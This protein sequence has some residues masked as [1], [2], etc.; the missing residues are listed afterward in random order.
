[1]RKQAK[2]ARQVAKAEMDVAA[3]RRAAISHQ[4]SNATW[5]LHE[6]EKAGHPLRL[7]EAQ[8]KTQNASLVM[9]LADA[10]KVLRSIA[11]RVNNFNLA[12]RMCASLLL[13]VLANAANVS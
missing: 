5:I 8:A 1:M 6:R 3:E 7:E 12:N 4:S 2:R 9:K 11:K 13:L 10:D